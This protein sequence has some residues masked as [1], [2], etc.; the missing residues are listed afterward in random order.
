MCIKN[1]PE[2]HHE[3]EGLIKATQLILRAFLC[4]QRGLYVGEVK[5]HSKIAHV[6]FAIHW[7]ET[8]A[9]SQIF[10]VV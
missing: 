3:I 7:N 9:T 10:L 8:Y 4:M 6:P 2:Q 5:I 1:I